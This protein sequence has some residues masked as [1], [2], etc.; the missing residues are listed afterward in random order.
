M[1]NT[2][3]PA[4]LLYNLTIIA[5]YCEAKIFEITELDSSSRNELKLDKPNWRTTIS[6][7]QFMLE[8]ARLLIHL[9]WK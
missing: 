5:V 1:W 4:G 6:G 9:M 3:I 7:K 2:R 8:F